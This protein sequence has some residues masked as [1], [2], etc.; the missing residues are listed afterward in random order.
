MSVK[1]QIRALKVNGELV[2]ERSVLS[3]VLNEQF[4]SVFTI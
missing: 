1:E 4:K 3:N 2:T